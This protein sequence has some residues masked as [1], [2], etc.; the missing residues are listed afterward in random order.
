V[1]VISDHI[2]QVRDNEAQRRYEVHLDG[3]LVGSAGYVR[4]GGRAYLVHTEID[5]GHEGAG[6]GS[7][8][9]R[10]AL[11]AQR[12]R[13]ELVVPLCPFVRAYL[14]RHPQYADVVDAEMLATIEGE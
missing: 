11:E 3:M 13:G 6:L 12:E 2:P 9:V 10:G 1:G 7:T 5:P 8:L 14:D 4:R